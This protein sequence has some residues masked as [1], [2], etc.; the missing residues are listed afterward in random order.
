MT[1]LKLY[2]E[3][4]DTGLPWLRQIPS[5]WEIRRNSQLF[6][7]RNETGF[8]NLPILEVSLRTGVRV[9]DLSN[10]KRKQIMEDR[11]KYKR[12]AKGDIAYNMMRMWQG[13]VGAAPID[14]LVSPAYV[15][16]RPYPNVDSRYYSYLFRTNAYMNEVNKW[17]RG[18]V[19]DRNRLYWDEFKQ[20]PSVFP[21]I[22][23]QEKI[24][25]FL[26]E[27]GR[28]VRKF[29]R[30]KQRLIKLL[31]EQKDAIIDHALTRGIHPHAAFA[32]SGLEWFGEL[33]EGWKPV[34]IK[35]I[36]AVR[37]SGVDKHSVEG[38]IP[39]KLC[40]YTD[41]YKHEEITQTIDFMSATAKPAEIT[42][43]SLRSGDVL[44]TKDSES[45]ADI[46]VPALVK[47]DLPGVVCGYHLALIRPDPFAIRSEF[48]YRAFTSPLLLR[49]FNIAA[50]GVTRYSLSKFDI[51][52]AVFPLPPL[53]EQDTICRWIDEQLF[54]IHNAI[55]RAIKEIDLIR[56][57]SVRLCKDLLT[58]QVDIRYL[59][60]ESI[61]PDLCDLSTNSS[62]VSTNEEDIDLE[63]EDDL[64]DEEG[65]YEDG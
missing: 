53:D 8:P 52:N 9:R 37:L 48:L 30:N 11:A 45:W 1:N 28:R 26:D 54:P 57:Y 42:N 14:G 39:I 20:M 59:P 65:E 17:S 61:D 43:L 33:P 27:H 15:V 12:V 35:Q 5:H 44:I 2:P 55:Q 3:Y 41:V 13:A 63:N 51:K 56:E 47:E 21:P 32:P 6:S 29:I 4:K 31:Y 49:Q 64:I 10:S 46:A 62:Y 50:T 24:A 40:N 23:E 25:N 60:I 36:A 58:G 18:I 38:E 16:A 34:S 22:D 7:Q 19:S